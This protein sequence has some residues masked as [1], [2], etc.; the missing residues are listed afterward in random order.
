MAS[1][2]DKRDSSKPMIRRKAFSASNDGSLATVVNFGDL[3]E[4]TFDEPVAHGGSDKG[5]TPLTG[6]LA[7]LC[8]CKAVTLGRTAHEMGFEYEGIEFDAAFT[9]DIRGRS[10]IRGVVPHFQAVKVGARVRTQESEACLANI[11]EETEA[12]CPVF[13][14]IKDAGVRIEMIWLRDSGD[15]G[16]MVA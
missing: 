13:N 16:A 15:A 7:S 1:V 11:V 6:V 10:G 8:G 3:G 12:R 5:H 9:I 2:V 4:F 14:L